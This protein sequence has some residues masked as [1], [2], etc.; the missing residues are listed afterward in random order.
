M[1]WWIPNERIQGPVAAVGTDRWAEGLGKL[2]LP[3][4]GS[5][6]RCYHIVMKQD[7]LLI[8]SGSGYK[9]WFGFGK[10]NK[11]HGSAVRAMATK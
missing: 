5:L 3:I 8:S 4:A 1:F 11:D 10:Y 2:K 6:C 9:E 7:I